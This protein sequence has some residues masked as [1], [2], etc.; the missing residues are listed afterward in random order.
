MKTFYDL[1]V[2]VIKSFFDN[3]M[4][5]LNEILSQN[6]IDKLLRAID[7]KVDEK[8]Q[9]VLN[10]VDKDVRTKLKKVYND[11]VKRGAFIINPALQKYK[12]DDLKD[13]FKKELEKRV[14]LSLS[15]IKTMDLNTI[16]DIKNR[17][18]NWAISSK[19]YKN[20]NEMEKDFW[21]DVIPAKVKEGF[22]GYKWQNM[23]IR[24]QQHKLVSNMT[25]ITALKNNAI[26]FIWKTRK[27]IR[28]VGN[29]SG[30]YPQGNNLHNNHYNRDGK[31]YLFRNSDFI[32]KGLIKKTSSVDYIDEID[33]GIPG[34]PI[35]CRCT[36]RVVYRLYDIPEY[37]RDIITKKGLEEL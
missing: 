34:Q 28:V 2:E 12:L 16:N 13:D 29:P 27:D 37:C 25:Y 33:D 11:F 3:D 23:I 36:M 6:K 18:T 19:N 1:I 15:Y 20:L 30:L 26:G 17:L 21:D 35:N 10:S 9:K 32:K 22:K 4:I 5:D 14:S 8:Y 7:K 31:F 24:D